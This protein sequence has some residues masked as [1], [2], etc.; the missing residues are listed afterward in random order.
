MNTRFVWPGAPI[1]LEMLI[2][3]G[4]ECFIQHD[5]Y[6]G[7][8]TDN[9]W[10]EALW[11]ALHALD[12]SFFADEGPGDAVILRQV[13]SQVQVDLVTKVFECRIRERKPAAYITGKGFFAG[14]EF[15]VS[16]DV[17]VPRSPIAE[18]VENHFQPW[19]TA[20]PKR[21]LDLGTGSGCIGIACA[22][23]FPDAEV[24]CSDVSEA[25]LRVAEQNIA[26][27]NL[28]HRVRAIQSDVYAALTGPYDLIVSNPPYVDAEDMASMP[29]EYHAE[30]VLGLAAGDD[31][32]DICRRILREATRY[33]NPEGCLIV[34]VG[35]SWQALEQAFPRVP[36]TWIE[37][38]YGGEGVFVLS[39]QELQQYAPYFG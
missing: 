12:Q 10:D 18:L 17:L 22:H 31:G 25:A 27:H 14:L 26:L 21:I 38:A 11:L 24:E 6:F 5:L 19:L 23:A 9:A 29:S 37:F 3:R 34:E 1:N 7:H 36:F 13:L 30:P 20:A 4:A 33:L 16:S 32:L 2:E 15:L 28:R 39:G 35:N 8:G